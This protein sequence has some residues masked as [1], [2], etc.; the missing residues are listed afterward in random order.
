MFEPENDLERSFVRAAN[1]PPH[2]PDFFRELMDAQIFLALD[3][4]G[5]PPIAGPDGQ[6]TLPKGTT[7]NLR[8]LKSGDQAFLPFFTAPSRARAIFKNDH[9]VVP[10][11]PRELFRRYPEAQFVLNP[12]WPLSKDFLRD[13]VARFLKGDFAPAIE[14]VT[15]GE[16]TQILFAQPSPYPHDIVAG[17]SAVF[18]EEPAIATAYLAQ[19]AHGGKPPHLA[20]AVDAAED[21]DTLMQR[22]GPRMR[23]VLPPSQPIDFFPLSGGPLENNFRSQTQPFF[24]RR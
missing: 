13:E 3:F 14:L 21:W 4:A 6:M 1:E 8:A 9:I 23:T 19:I 7:L 12:G 10:D 5:A 17:L 11:T 20:I 2:R 15:A 16:G 22:L 24:K 18:Q